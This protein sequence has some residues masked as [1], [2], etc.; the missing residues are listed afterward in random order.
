ML[1]RVPSVALILLSLN[2]QREEPAFEI[3]LHPFRA[4]RP[5][6]THNGVEILR[7]TRA[8]CA[9]DL[10]VSSFKLLTPLSHF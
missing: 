7:P 4:A 8:L 2:L 9:D 10:P 6:L 5:K 1:S 3:R